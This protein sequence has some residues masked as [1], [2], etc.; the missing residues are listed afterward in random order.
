VENPNRQKAAREHEK[1]AIEHMIPAHA[2][3]FFKNLKTTQNP[4]ANSFG[5]PSCAYMLAGLA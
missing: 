4:K 2:A 5:R 3:F 1:E